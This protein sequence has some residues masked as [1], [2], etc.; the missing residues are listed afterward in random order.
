MENL[1]RITIAAGA[2]A[3]IT[4]CGQ[5]HVPTVTQD[6]AAQTSGSYNVVAT[7]GSASGAVHGRHPSSGLLDVNGT[8]YG[9]T[10][11]GGGKH[12]GVV[13]SIDP[14]GKAKIVYRFR[15]GSD[16]AQP[17]G[18]LIDVNGT[19]YGTTEFGGSS[20]CWDNHGC[21]TV[22]SLTTTGKE[23]V[24]HSFIG[25]CKNC[26][27]GSLPY[28]LIDVN[29]TLYGTAQGGG[30]SQ[31]YYCCGIFYSI[32]TSGKEKVLHRFVQH[33]GDYPNGPLVSVSGLL[34]G[35]TYSGGAGG[36]GTVFSFDTAGK[37]KTVFDFTSGSNGQQGSLAGLIE[38]GGTLYG[39]TTGPGG[40]TIFSVT[41]SGSETVLHRF[42]TSSDGSYPV[43]ALTNANGV[44]YG[45]T[46]S[47]G[48]GT[49]QTISYRAGCGTL[50]TVTT[51]G[52]ESV[53][54]RFGG[55]TDGSNPTQDL[56]DVGGTLYGTTPNGGTA[57]C[58]AGCGTLFTY[59]P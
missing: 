44:L 2:A 26:R 10:Y 28:G 24:L 50:F 58:V 32:T 13:F 9:T 14:Q 41:P 21:G 47:G 34:Y 43:A 12:D 54:H 38:V 29:G 55:G 39:T 5:S 46:Q 45:S 22:F 52:S 17:N 56:L 57:V 4:A 1:A 37:E 49:C 36:G 6:A 25:G 11:D 7:F 8:L 23:K 27:D 20:H 53:L 51:T 15:G 3:L 16:G 42:A 31:G 48:G 59:T 40:G 33:D 30:I 18:D 35:T 19:L